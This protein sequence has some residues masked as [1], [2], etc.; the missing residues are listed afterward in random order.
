M[1]FAKKLCS[2]LNFYYPIRSKFHFAHAMR[3]K[4]EMTKRFK[5]AVAIAAVSAL[6]MSSAANAGKPCAS[7]WNLLVYAKKCA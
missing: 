1:V 7:V 2:L 4:C 5:L 3:S 6:S